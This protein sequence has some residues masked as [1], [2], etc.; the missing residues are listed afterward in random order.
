MLLLHTHVLT[1]PRD[2]TMRMA[3]AQCHMKLK[4][5][6]SARDCIENA[7]SIEPNHATLHV[8]L[9]AHAFNHT[10]SFQ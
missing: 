8:A 2:L 5:Y 6:V 3:L 9:G 1:H 4:E 10:F 7:I